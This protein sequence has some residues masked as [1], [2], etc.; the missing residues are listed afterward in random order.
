MKYVFLCTCLA[1]ILLSAVAWLWQPRE[2]DDRI[3]LTWCSDD[4]PMRREQIARFNE[5]Y[6]EYRLSLDPQSNQ[7]EKV[8]VQSLAGVGPDLFDCYSG[9]Q[10]NAFVRSGI[11]RDCTDEM[12]AMGIK[13]EDAW[14][15]VHP[16]M[17][18]DGRLYGYPG[19]ANA[20]AVWYNKKIFDE[21]GVPYPSSDWTW[22]EF[23]AIS[24]RL[25]ARGGRGQIIRFG[26]IG[27]WDWKAVLFQFGASFYTPEGTR[28]ILDSK[29]ACDSMQF[30]QDLTYAH[31]AIPTPTQQ[32]AMASAGGW[33][34]GEIALFGAERSAMA[35]GGRW[36]LCILR[37]PSYDHLDLGAVEMPALRLSDGTLSTRIWGG[38][39]STLVNATGKHVEGALL[40]MEYL[41][42]EHWNN[43]IN[44]QADAL[45][46]VKK[47]NYTPDFLHN[48]EHPEEDYNAVWRAALENSEPEQ[49]SPYVNGQ[50]VERLMI[51]QTDLVKDNQKSG[52]DAMRDAC[53]KINEAI[54]ETIEKDPVLRTKYFEALENGAQPAWD[55][56]S[57]APNV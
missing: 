7:V 17:L 34:T 45:A 30:M 54:V 56:E 1:M 46:P 3:S 5:L 16:H 10:L 2:T 25:T 57:G 38:G 31:E 13:A 4:N 21:E 23:I 40:F 55:D 11:A 18:H 47:Y 6:P 26:M 41:H 15:A 35:I 22:D 8:I 50:F 9:F 36:W 19:N 51:V 12:A 42:S 29:E 43:L 49:V 14:K 37:N 27:Y 20:P 24:K 32:A 53:R 48:P 52:A 44:E 28:C 39:R 33:G